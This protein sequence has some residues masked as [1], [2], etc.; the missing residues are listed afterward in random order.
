VAIRLVFFQIY[1]VLSLYLV[2]IIGRRILNRGEGF[3]YTRRLARFIHPIY[4]FGW[5]GFLV[6]S[7][8]IIPIHPCLLPL[9]PKL[10]LP[11]QI[12]F[13]IYFLLFILSA[14]V[15]LQGIGGLASRK[16][17]PIRFMTEKFIKRGV[18]RYT[19]NPMSLG[20]YLFLIG[21][22]IAF[23]SSYLLLVSLV[24]IIPAHTFYLKIYE[25]KELELKFG[26][27]YLKYKKEVPFLFPRIKKRLAG[28]ESR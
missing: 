16:I 22:A 15:G 20:G 19:R 14:I 3:D 13:A 28:R 25:E 5:V 1:C 24:G 8:I 12:S 27:E 21:Y 18:R 9:L 4:A 10:I 23:S 17:G 26:K 7:I 11:R 2:T 6:S